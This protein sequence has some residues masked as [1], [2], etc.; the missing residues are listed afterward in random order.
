M[1]SAPDAYIELLDRVERYSHLQDAAMT[2]RWD[3]QVTMPEAGAPS[4]SKQNAALSATSHDVITDQDVGDLLDELDGADLDPEQE[5]VVRETRREY[6]EA[7]RVPRDLVEE[8]SETSSQ[9]QGVWQEAKAED[10][11]EEFAPTL[12]TLRDLYRRRAEH[13]DP[14]RDPYRVMYEGFD[15]ALPLDLVEEV[16]AELRNALV[17]LIED[18][19]AADADL[20][21]LPDG[22]WDEETQMALNREAAEVIGYDFDRGRLDTSPH[23]FTA[24]NQ[25][26][27]RITT[28]V[29]PGDP[30]DA[31]TATIHEYGHASYQLGLPREE[32]GTPLGQPHWEIHESQSRFWENH[33]GRTEAFWEFFAP[34]FNDHLGT[35]LQSRE[36]YEI[37]NSITPENLIRVEADELT[38]HMHIILRTEVEKAF[39]GGDISVEEIPE[40]WNDTMEE[41][42]G[43]R[44]ETDAEGCLQDIHWT[45]GFGGFQ[46]YTVGSVLAAQLDAAMR[47]DLDEDV[48]ALIREGEFEPLLE[49][50]TENVHRHG[51]RYPADELIERATGEPLTA[52]YF[53]DYAERKF[54]S[55]YGL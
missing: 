12:V 8:I 16:F 35:D 27:C 13:V 48:D 30:M 55:L 1:S 26:D 53:I 7:T 44:P 20:V 6:E 19:K 29:R 2:L 15:P 24:G 5:A 54:G 14:D 47:E 22:E 9:A 3:Q 17:P 37:S 42:L 38:Y 4:R 40:V 32:Y 43:V 11:F 28:R 41:Y 45:H 46:S 51:K 52:E 18:L 50:M 10:D 34:T 21:A 23:P 39:V 31:L 49:W 33:V 25:F 36:L